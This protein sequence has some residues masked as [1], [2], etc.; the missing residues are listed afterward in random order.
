MSE[1]GGG[2][3]SGEPTPLCGG[4]W[5]YAG[6]HLLAWGAMMLIY[7]NSQERQNVKAEKS[8]S[9]GRQAET[10]LVHMP[11]FTRGRSAT[12]LGVCRISGLPQEGDGRP[13]I[14][15]CSKWDLRTSSS[16][17][18]WDSS[19]TAHPLNQRLVLTRSTVIC[20]YTAAEGPLWACVSQICL[21][22]R[23]IGRAC[24]KYRF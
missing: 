14:P 6:P 24:L 21:M 9:R 10:L 4:A 13:P 5:P 2:E 20:T 11:G 15:R 12:C 19:P 17:S 18:S 22:L 7:N 3:R 1:P 8:G 16:S 23:I